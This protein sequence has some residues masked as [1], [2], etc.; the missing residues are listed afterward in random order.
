MKPA[1]SAIPAGA[2]VFCRTIDGGGS[3][4]DGQANGASV[5]LGELLSGHG[6]DA[7]YRCMLFASALG[8][9]SDPEENVSEHFAGFEPRALLREVRRGAKLRCSVCRR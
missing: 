4:T 7:H 6:I 9:P 1:I 2:C 8:Q 5:D 3:A